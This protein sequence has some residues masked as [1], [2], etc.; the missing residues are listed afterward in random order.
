MDQT[1]ISRP[2]VSNSSQGFSRLAAPVQ[3]WIRSKKWEKLRDIQERAIHAIMDSNR[4]VIIAAATAGGKTEAAFL[5]LISTVLDKPSTTTGFNLVYLS[6]LKALINDQFLRLCDLCERAELPVYPWHG[7]ISQSLKKRARKQPSGILLITPE[8]LEALFVLRGIEVQGMFNGVQAVVVDELHAFL[9]NERG[10]HVRSLLTRLELSVGHQIRRIGLSATLSEMN[11]IRKYLR[12]ENPNEVEVLEDTSSDFWLKAQI[13]AYLDSK[14]NELETEDMDENSARNAVVQHLFNHL[15]GKRNLIFAG[16]RANVELYSDALRVLSEKKRFPLEF[17]PHH[18]SLSREHRMDL[19]ERLRNHPATTAVC[20]STLELGIDIGDIECVAQIGAPFSVSSLRQRLGRSGRRDGAPAILRMYHTGKEPDAKSNPLDRLFLGLIQSIAM[21]E[22]LKQRWCEPPLPQALHLSTLTHQIL[23]IIA[24]HG[25]RHAHHIYETLCKQG[26]FRLVTPSIF[27]RILRQLGSSEVALIEQTSDGALLLGKKGERIVEHYSFY[28]VFETP[29]EYRIL[30][31]GKSLG[32]LPL[33]MVMVPDMTIIFSGRRWRIIEIDEKR[34]VINVSA[35]RAGKPPIFDGGG[36][37]IHDRVVTEMR[38]VLMDSEVPVY[39][40]KTASELL[41]DARD[42]FQM[43]GLDTHVIRNTAARGS[44][45]ATW[46]GTIKSATLALVLKTMGYDVH[47]YH[48]GFL[49]VD[50]PK[51][52][53]SVEEALVKIAASDTNSYLSKISECGNLR[54]EKFHQYL[55]LDLL[56]EDA[57][58]S[59]LD[60]VALPDLARTLI[61]SSGK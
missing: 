13:Q 22:L 35:D 55:S 32:T 34:K 37:I 16:S 2:S 41:K 57:A 18:A 40:D 27:K 51:S 59:R 21:V 53:P 60:F 23:A 61:G 38:K 19:E 12:P 6:P 52:L 36:G 11:L 7:D 20:T 45:I 5:P 30:A 14:K 24:E 43:L 8:S 42:E 1:M 48:G 54:T 9:D 50:W 17:L 33:T 44:I 26:P 56:V 25:G 47:L 49:E 31:E 28:A 4:D 15:R 39:L 29:R 10:I 46:V 3:R 58:S